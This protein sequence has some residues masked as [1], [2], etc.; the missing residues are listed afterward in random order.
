MIREV[1]FPMETQSENH[2]RGANPWGGINRTAAQRKRV[3]EVLKEAFVPCAMYLENWQGNRFVV[4]MCRISVQYLDD[5]NLRGSLK[6]V[7][8]EIAKWLGFRDDSHAWIEFKYLMQKCKSGY[9]GVRV[10]IQCN[11]QG[12]DQRHIVGT[13]PVLIGEPVERATKNDKPPPRVLPCYAAPSWA[14]VGPDEYDLI[15]LKLGPTPP[16]KIKMTDPATKRSVLLRRTEGK[17]DDGPFWLYVEAF[18]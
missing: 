6:G 3:K 14:K 12:K 4:T 8:D 1:T 13:A 9:Q 17:D 16:E 5:D 18:E 2:Y 15:E 11:E 7:R 10:T